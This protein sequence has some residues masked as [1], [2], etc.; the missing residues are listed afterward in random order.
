M[1]LLQAAIAGGMVL[2]VIL[3]LLSVIVVPSLTWLFMRKLRSKQL[4]STDEQQLNKPVAFFF[5]LVIAIIITGI[6]FVLFI[7]L[8]DRIFPGYGYSN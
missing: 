8:F 2:Y 3:L 5:A 7:L 1:I 4:N 6:L